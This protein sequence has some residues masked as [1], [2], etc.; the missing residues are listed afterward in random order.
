MEH[1]ECDV[2]TSSK[3]RPSWGQVPVWRVATLMGFFAMC[4]V[5]S[6]LSEYFL[7]F[8]NLISVLRQISIL[9]VI[10]VGITIVQAAG[11]FDLSPGYFV[12][13][14]GVVSAGVMRAGGGTAIAILAALVLGA[15]LG[16]MNGGLVAYVGIPAFI[17]T[18]ATGTIALG[19]NFLYTR[20]Y[21]I[22]EGMT[23]RFRWLG[24]GYVGP[25]PVPIIILVSVVAIFY[26]IL[27]H[28]VPGRHLYATGGNPE[29]ALLSGIN[30]RRAKLL[31]F[32]LGGI[33]TGMTAVLLAARLGSGQ[34]TAG[35]ELTLEGYAA[36]FIGTSVNEEGEFA[37][38]GTFLG[39]LMMGVLAN[40]LTLLN[41]PYYFQNIAKGLVLIGA[42][43]AF[44]VQRSRRR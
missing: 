24:D 10:S 13:L 23:V 39:T 31:A 16:T 5:F 1:K 44:A 36:V 8:R 11:E 3:N 38:L 15:L 43:T 32:V 20:G 26:F 40:G 4:V 42:V 21:P 12:G 27:H 37:V 19:V 17:A 14:I 33:T 2:K 18:L 25:I 22:F 7:T 6:L 30:V 9:G 28:T 41:V 29:A 35:Q 34:P